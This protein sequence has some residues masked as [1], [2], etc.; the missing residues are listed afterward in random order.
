MQALLRETSPGIAGLLSAVAEKLA[1][2]S[3]A[4][5]EYAEFERILEALEAAPRDDD[6]AHISTLVGRILNQEQWLY[7][8][9]EALASQPLNP[10]IPRLL[11]RSPDRLIDRLG[12]LLTAENGLNSLPAMVRLIHGDGANQ[13]LGALEFRLFEA[14]KQRVAT[15]IH[16]AR[17]SRSETV[18]SRAAQSPGELGMEPAGPRR[19]GTYEVDEPACRGSDGTSFSRDTF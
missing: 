8:V 19:D 10:V 17:F 3:L 1:R 7:L 16:L 4:K 9:D 12:L 2:T 18:G 6:H 14:R 15:A 13:F 11:K 5:H